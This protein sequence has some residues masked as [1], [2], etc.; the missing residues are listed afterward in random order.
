MLLELVMIEF[1][2]FC[3][4]LEGWVGLGFCGVIALSCSCLQCFPFVTSCQR[5]S[6]LTQPRSWACGC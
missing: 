6:M 5:L 3:R 2:D 1:L 4:V